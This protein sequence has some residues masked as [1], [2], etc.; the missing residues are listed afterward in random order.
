[1]G[2][3]YED[4]EKLGRLRDKGIITEEEFKEKKEKILFN[5]ES[6]DKDLVIVNFLIWG[7]IFILILLVR[8]CGA[9]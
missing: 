8:G 5:K 3:K 6:K 1:M 4:L 9:R 7:L 2:K